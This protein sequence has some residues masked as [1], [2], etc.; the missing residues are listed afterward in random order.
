MGDDSDEA[1]V[2]RREENSR[3][4]IDNVSWVGI[5]RGNPGVFQL[6]PYPTPRKPLP[7]IRVRVLGGWGKGF[8]KTQ[9]FVQ[10][11]RVFV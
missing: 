8:L 3:S 2:K 5:I 1:T 11:S 10:L 9:G 7:S 6:Y 4:D